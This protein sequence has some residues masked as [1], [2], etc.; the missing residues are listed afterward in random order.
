[1]K[2]ISA[3]QSPEQTV[4]DLA[5][6]SW[7]ALIALHISRQDGKSLSPLTTHTFLLSWLASAQKQ[8]RFPRSVA[9]DIDGLLR[10]GRLKGV[11]AN[12]LQRF[13]YLYD[14]CISPIKQQSDLFRLTFAIEALKSQGWLNVVVTDEEWNTPALSEEHSHVSALLVRKSELINSFSDTGLLFRPVEFLVTGD[15]NTIVREFNKQELHHRT[16]AG[17]FTGHKLTLLPIIES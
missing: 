2:K 10:L 16:D 13:E 15:S 4:A 6:L 8:R 11:A 7:C 17:P 12:L 14:S 9:Q 1:M 3:P 5:H